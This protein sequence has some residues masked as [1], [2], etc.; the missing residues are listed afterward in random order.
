MLEDILYAVVRYSVEQVQC[1]AI[2]Y[3]NSETPK[4]YLAFR[5]I[6]MFDLLMIK[7]PYTPIGMAIRD[8]YLRGPFACQV[9]ENNLHVN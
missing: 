3:Q 8:A 4:E 6:C 5:R 7:D 2:L 9:P 1:D